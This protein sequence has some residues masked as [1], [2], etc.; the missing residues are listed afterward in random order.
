MVNVFRDVRRQVQGVLANQ[1]FGKLRILVLQRLDDI[2]VT[3]G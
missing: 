3:D 2:H 1:P